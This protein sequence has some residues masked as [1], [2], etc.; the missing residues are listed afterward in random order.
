MKKIYLL[1]TACFLLASISLL[2]QTADK[3]TF[4]KKIAG[5]VQLLN[6]WVEWNG[7]S[8]EKVF[9]IKVAEE[10]KYYLSALGNFPNN[11][12]TKIKLN[13]AEE[14]SIYTD[15]GDWKWVG[16]ELDPIVLT[17][18]THKIKIDNGSAMAPMIDDIFFYKNAAAA[19]RM[20]E[21]VNSFFQTLEVLKNGTAS[22]EKVLSNPEGIYTHA[23]DTAF[24]YSNYS[25]VYLNPGSHQVTTSNSTITPNLLVFAY[26]SM[27]YSGGNSNGGGNGE[28]SL[29]FS[30]AAS[31]YYSILLRPVSNGST[32]TCNILVDGNVSVSNAVI[33][34]RR[35]S[36]PTLKG[37]NL[38][39][40]TCKL[41]SGDD[42][43]LVVSRYSTSSA[44][45]YNDDYYNAS[46]TFNW[47]YASRIK[48]DFSGVDSVQYAFVCAYSPTTYGTCDVYM[49][50]EN[51]NVY[52]DNYPEFPLLEADDAIKA[53]PSSGYY[54]CIS[55]SGGITNTWVW[56]PSWASTYNCSGSSTDVTCFDNFYGNNP[57][58]YP[59]AKTYT[60]S[61]ATSSNSL[62]DLWALNGTYTHGSVRKPG[63]DHPHGYDWESKPGGLTRT[64][65]PRS[66]L[67]NTSFGYG[68]VVN[69]YR[70]DP[71]ARMAATYASDEDAVKAGVAIFDN[72]ILTDAAQ[73][74]LRLLMSKINPDFVSQ[75]NTLYEAWNK[76]KEKNAIYS[77][78]AMYCK[79]AEY[80]ALAAQAKKNARNTLILTID[81]YVNGND[82]FIGELLWSL[83]KTT[84]ERLL[85]EVKQERQAKPNDEQGRYRIHGDH[86]NGVLYVEKIL[87]DLQPVNE[88]PTAAELTT[89]T[90]SPNPVSDNYMVKLVLAKDAMV[91]IKAIYTQSKQITVLQQPAKLSAGVHIF[92]GNIIKGFVPSGE[93]ISIQAEIDG[94]IKS[95]KAIIIK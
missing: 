81:K 74:K 91:S 21:K 14:G 15:K 20:P 24:T 45:G 4:T 31:G 80:E 59:G 76:T 78:P 69:Y 85:T 89:L 12:F 5:D 35:F 71:N 34:G 65:H 37:G 41:S 9:T 94:E 82:H 36:I 46:G 83:S 10:A 22:A 64:F 11:S 47:G 57:V 13:D 95:L 16:S 44:R 32:G 6:S 93:M 42:T 33:G 18:G 77:D 28:A 43:R 2:A 88:L 92:N 87:K 3:K 51:S 68:A 39:F 30:V 53:A 79:N 8:L 19:A 84:Y 73:A 49:A 55:W 62:V 58:R 54:N 23:V 27:S 72:A 66:A 86:D 61:G 60:R 17:V 1:M 25:L 7:R 63:N 38:N 67:T 29:S 50:N 40:F 90:I 48:K 52:K 26:P 70:Y 75:F 56:P